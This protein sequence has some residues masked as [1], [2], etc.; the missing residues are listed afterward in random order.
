MRV[1]GDPSVSV[2]SVLYTKIR[3][4]SSRSPEAYPFPLIL[5]NFLL[6]PINLRSHASSFM[7]ERG[8]CV[9]S[10]YVVGALSPFEM[11]ML[12]L[13]DV[14]RG[15]G[16]HAVQRTCGVEIGRYLSLPFA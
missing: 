14:D 15:D 9:M 8:E 2:Y 13:R 6:R 7:R 12:T 4:G 3:L 16:G 5:L 1:K 10:R 11:G